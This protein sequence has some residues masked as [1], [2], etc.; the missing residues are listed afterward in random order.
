MPKHSN[1]NLKNNSRRDGRIDRYREGQSKLPHLLCVKRLGDHFITDYSYDSNFGQEL[2]GEHIDRQEYFGLVFN[3]CS[4]C[5]LVLR[6]FVC[7]RPKFANFSYFL[8]L[9]ALIHFHQ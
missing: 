1:A 2:L 8:K 6:S 9:G 4:N 7:M 3:C 5:G